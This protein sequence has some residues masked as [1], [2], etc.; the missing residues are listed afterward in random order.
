VTAASPAG[1][2]VST[3]LPSKVQ[4]GT[5]IARKTGNNKLTISKHN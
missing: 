2:H 3:Q 5:E 4:K 1:C